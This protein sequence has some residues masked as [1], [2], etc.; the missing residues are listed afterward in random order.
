MRIGTEIA[1]WFLCWHGSGRVVMADLTPSPGNASSNFGAFIERETLTKEALAGNQSP[2]LL[3]Y[4][5]NLNLRPMVVCERFN[6][7]IDSDQAQGLRGPG[8]VHSRI[9][10]INR[11]RVINLL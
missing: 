3:G 2:W 1:Q 6:M 8:G 10:L 4:Q 7:V 9:S 5:K 11:L